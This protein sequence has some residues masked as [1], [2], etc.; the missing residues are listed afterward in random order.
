M[1]DDSALNSTSP[2]SILRVR[3]TLSRANEHLVISEAHNRA[4][5]P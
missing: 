4:L 5:T 3:G 1:L 2:N